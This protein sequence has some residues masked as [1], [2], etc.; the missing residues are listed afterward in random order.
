M[1]WLRL[2]FRFLQLGPMALGAIAAA[3][4]GAG[5]YLQVLDN[6]RTAQQVQALRAGQ[7]AVVDLTD[8]RT[9]EALSVIG[10]VNAQ[11]QLAWDYSYDLWYEES[12][13][14]DYVVMFPLLA[15]NSSS[16]NEVIGVALFEADDDSFT[17]LSPEMVD[18][19]FVSDGVHGPVMNLN[20]ELD[21]MGK[22]QDL[23]EDSFYDEGLQ[24][25]ADPIV[26]WPY[27][28]GRDVALAPAQPGDLTIF[29]VLS[30][31][32][33]V[34]G[35]IALGKMVFGRK[36]EDDAPLDRPETADVVMDVAAVETNAAPLWK[37]RAGL[38]DPS[39]FADEPA[40]FEPAVFD[41]PTSQGATSE[42]PVMD[43]PKRTGFGVRKVLIGVVGALFV[44]GLVATISDLIAKS[45]STETVAEISTQEIFA[46][47][48]ADIVVPDADPNRHWT[49]IDVTPVIEWFV[50]KSIL[51]ASGD[52]EAQITMGM[53]FGG[54]FVA[55]V[56]L[57][58]F[59][60]MRRNLRPRTTA[61]FD[62]MGLG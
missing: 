6:E 15:P 1:T 56:M 36:P 19:W 21:K 58:F 26:I 32:A 28:Q 45:S 3:I 17:T 44:L 34:I 10:E 24:M 22:W 2:F 42:V 54:F 62:S 57:R 35:L 46:Q 23:V 18:A 53:I 41:T 9:A 16:L 47:T 8:A 40:T 38:V 7:P 55:M 39:D 14:V 37:Q 33:G 48:A 4:L 20:G 61:R 60:V 25:P 31:V 51:A 29:G 30:K 11:A 50:A 27:V 59:F 49:D 13:G 12:L 5:F 52:A 43:A